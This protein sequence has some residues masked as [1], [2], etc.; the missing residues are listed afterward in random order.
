MKMLRR[1][2]AKITTDNNKIIKA[3]FIK[4]PNFSKRIDVQKKPSLSFNHLGD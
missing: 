1:N 2:E 4:N 3:Q